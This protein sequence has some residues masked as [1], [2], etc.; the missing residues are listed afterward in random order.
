MLS[1]NLLKEVLLVPSIFDET[2]FTVFRKE[3]NANIG[4]ILYVKDGFQATSAISGDRIIHGTLKFAV[5]FLL[6]SKVVKSK[7][8]IYLPGQS[9]LIDLLS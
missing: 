3:D 6:N 2:E 5:Y 1:Q 4:V 7:K 8:T 9:L